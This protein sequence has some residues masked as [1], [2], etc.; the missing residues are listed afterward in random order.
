MDREYMSEEE[1]YRTIDCC[2][3]DF[4]DSRKKLFL[5]EEI[6]P[7]KVIQDG[8]YTYKGVKIPVIIQEERYKEGVL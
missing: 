5:G 3:S 7:A 2:L 1:A 8:Y 4:E 6:A